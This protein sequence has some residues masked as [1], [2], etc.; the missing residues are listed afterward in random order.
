MTLRSSSWLVSTLVCA[1]ACSDS[2]P[3]PKLLAGENPIQSGTVVDAGLSGTDAGS[4]GADQPPAPGRADDLPDSCADVQTTPVRTIPSVTFLVDGSSSMKCV[5]PEDPACDCEQQLRGQCVGKGKL[6]RWHAL[7]EALF[8]DGVTPGLIQS[9]GD[10]IRFGLWIYNNGPGNPTCPAFPAKVAPA[11]SQSSQLSGAFPDQPPGYNTPTGLALGELAAALP[12]AQEA[13]DRQLGP[14]KIVLATDGQPFVCYDPVTLQA[15]A[16][17]YAGVI[18]A[19]Q[20]ARARSIDVYVM[21]LAPTA[22]DFAS[23]LAEV[24]Q[25]GNTSRP[26]APADKTQLSAALDEIIASAISCT[27]SL[28]G[29]IQA[30]ELCKGSA[31]LGDQQLTCGDADGFAIVAEDKVELKGEACRRFKHEPGIALSMTFP[32]EGL[33]LQ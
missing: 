29:K 3:E 11:L 24:A 2:D 5:Y 31:L 30:P 4:P 33:A 1:V 21:S 32:C 6:S 7:S 26:F 23:H 13:N 22:G 17:D 9:R 20:A 15:P 12:S 16:L 14:Q 25:L 28:H 10:S 27:V 19:T 18:G 8:G